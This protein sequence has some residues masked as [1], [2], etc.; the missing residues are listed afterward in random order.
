MQLDPVVAEALKTLFVALLSA[1]VSGSLLVAERWRTRS[2]TVE[3]DLE[4]ER[5]QKERDDAYQEQQRQWEKR[6]NELEARSREE[7]LAN[8][9]AVRDTMLYNM[10]RVEQLE[11][12]N[13]TL[14]HQI[15]D[16]KVLIED[17]QESLAARDKASQERDRKF[18]D[19]DKEM[20]MLRV[21]VRELKLQLKGKDSEIESRD[22]TI[23]ELNRQIR[24][25][26]DELKLLN[27]RIV[28]LEHPSKPMIPTLPA[29]SAADDATPDL[30]IAS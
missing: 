13:D 7:E 4:Y 10:R 24:D 2:K 14:A 17:L 25:L 15:A 12:Q 23:A 11:A 26:R 6:I 16:A 1:L 30:P 8:A 18:A 19:Q 21:E 20:G 5:K 27:A 28:E 29:P 9:K 22:A 3:R